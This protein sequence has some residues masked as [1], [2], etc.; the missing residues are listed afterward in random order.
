M[1][2]AGSN[3]RKNYLS[4]RIMLAIS[5]PL[6]LLGVFFMTI[7]ITHQIENLRAYNQI[8]NRLSI[9]G[10]RNELSRLLEL[11]GAEG[12]EISGSIKENAARIQSQFDAEDIAVFDAAERNLLWDSPLPWSSTDQRTAYESL[13]KKSLGSNYL[14]KI[15]S[16]Q[17]RL[18]AYIP[19]ISS[20]P[21]A[22]YVIRAVFYL[23]GIREA[24]ASSRGF[25]LLMMLALIFIG[26]VI[27]IGL[28][29]SIVKPIKK[30][31][32][33]TQEI[34]EGRLGQQISIRTGDE[35]ESLAN[36]FNH[37]S[38]SL[39]E[40]KERAEDANP[41][42]QFP[43]NKEIHHEIQKRIH[44]RQKFVLFHIDVDRFK[45]FN[46]HFGLIKGDDTIRLTANLLRE[47]VKLKG[48]KDDFIGHQGGDDFI[49]ITRPQKA[50]ELA[51]FIAER[52]D[53]EVKEKVYPKEDYEKGYTLE[54]D[55][56]NVSTS[57]VPNLVKF[58]LI[59]ISVA[60]V[61]TAKSDFADISDLMKK[62]IEAKKQAKKVVENSYIILE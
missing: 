44:E 11:S 33:A 31:N 8:K 57:G 23:A 5:L 49:I 16:A 6:I 53:S 55:R 50:E 9:D 36:A 12:S 24:L 46:D 60:G 13:E 42:T 21:P 38:E 43:G 25:L 32:E 10:I 51:K 37:M 29:N 28:A 27:A 40:M 22:Q 58:P 54:A 47:A 52:Y 34:M 59:A 30:L 2:P 48:S 14:I 35:L 4:L 18:S 62:A 17:N 1:V 19:V 15:D 39:K 20:N 45:I 41:L 3:V 26:F 56:R 7:Q 61:S